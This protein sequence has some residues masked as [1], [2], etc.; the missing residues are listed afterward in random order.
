MSKEIVF[1]VG[2]LFIKATNVVA[3]SVACATGAAVTIITLV[4]R[5]CNTAIA[6]LVVS[7]A[8]TVIRAM[9][10]GCLSR[11]IIITGATLTATGTF[12]GGGSRVTATPSEALLLWIAIF[13]RGA[14]TAALSFRLANPSGITATAAAIPSEMTAVTLLPELAVSS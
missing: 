1:S 10:T 11:L 9:T 6:P 4:V 2:L 5:G 7:F 14:V 12:G 3:I 13:S 8:V